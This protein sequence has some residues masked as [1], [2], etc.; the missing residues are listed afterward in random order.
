MLP[1]QIQGQRSADPKHIGLLPLTTMPPLLE[2]T[3][4]PPCMLNTAPDYYI[5]FHSRQQGAPDN[6]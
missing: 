2:V 4:S 3:V 1:A 6:V 5:L